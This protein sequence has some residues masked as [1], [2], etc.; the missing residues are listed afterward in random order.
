MGI[1]AGVTSSWNIHLPGLKVVDGR[2][3]ASKER[4]PACVAVAVVFYCICTK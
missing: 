3:A 4:V 2:L 1:V